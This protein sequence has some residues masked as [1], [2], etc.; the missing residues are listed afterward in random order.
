M[1]VYSTPRA[2]LQHSRG[3][4]SLVTEP[5]DPLH[6]PHEVF[7]A[8]AALTKP[9]ERWHA[10]AFPWQPPPTFCLA[11]GDR[12]LALPRRPRL[13]PQ[14][15]TRPEHEEA[16]ATRT[17]HSVD[18]VRARSSSQHDPTFGFTRKNCRFCRV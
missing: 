2:P 4:S 17:Q 14:K 15:A 6:L 3:H 1:Q 18:F 7:L 16:T 5:P 10:A 11:E 13:P 9:T 12:P 8:H